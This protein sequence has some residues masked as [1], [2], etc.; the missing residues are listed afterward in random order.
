MADGYDQ[1]GL[2]LETDYR[3]NALALHP[4]GCGC[5]NCDSRHSTPIDNSFYMGLFAAAVGHGRPLF[6]SSGVEFVLVQHADGKLEFI[7]PGKEMRVL[8]YIRVD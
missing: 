5:L 6:N 3:G 7:E 1:F 8:R 4:S 2:P